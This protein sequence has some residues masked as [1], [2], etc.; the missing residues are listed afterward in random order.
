M[1]ITTKKINE[2]LHL[3]GY[4]A[5]IQK[6]NGY[7]YFVGEDASDQNQNR[8]QEN[9]VMTMHLSGTSLGSWV[10]EFERIFT[11]QE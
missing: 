10:K 11:P 1:R 5:E 6:G 3:A 8:N 4:K 2:A 7:F 9:M